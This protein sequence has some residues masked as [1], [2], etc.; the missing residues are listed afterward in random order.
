MTIFD[1]IVLG[2]VEGVT[3]FIPVSS[4]GHLILA[5]DFLGL[6]DEASTRRSVDAFSIIIQGGA[7][8]AVLG[9]YRNKVLGML[10][11]IFAS[12]GLMKFGPDHRHSI[13]LARN[14]TL[15]FLPAAVI[16]LMFEDLI[17]SRLFRPVPVLVALFFGGIAMI[18]A[19]KTVRARSGVS[20]GRGP[21]PE[22]LV[23]M[24]ALLIGFA[25]CLAMW[26]GTSRS[27]VTILGGIGVGMRAKESAEFSFLLALPTLGAAC[28]WKLRKVVVEPGAVELLGGWAVILIGLAAATIAAFLSVKWLISY[29][30]RGGLAIFGWWRVALALLLGFAM[31]SGWIT[32][33]TS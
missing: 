22:T 2:I 5:A 17:Q 11:A 6:R 30:A 25:Q 4:T 18:L 8:L 9:L 19:S 32:L 16:G 21:G 7:I 15:A 1:A 23:P 3:E 13:G 33:G 29:L 20:Q 27:M 31:Y 24:Q 28:L 14:I 26:P 12:A 10:R